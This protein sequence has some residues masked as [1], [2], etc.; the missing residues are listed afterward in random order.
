[1]NEEY[2]DIRNEIDRID[3]SIAD[4]LN[5]RFTLARRIIDDKISRKVQLN[6]KEREYDIINRAKISSGDPLFKDLIE[7]I[8]RN[9]FTYSKS[10]GINENQPGSLQ[11]VINTAPLLIAGPCAVEN[12]EQIFGLA[13]YLSAI[14]I[15][16]LRGSAFKP[17]TNPVS[18]Q[19][20]GA[21]GLDLIREAADKNNMFLINEVVDSEQLETYYDKIDIIQIGSR[22]MTSSGFLKQ[23][24]KMTAADKKPV[25]LKRGFASTI[26]E[27]LF[28]AQYIINEGN[29]NVMLCLRGIRT[30]E[31]IDSI[32]RYT[33][34]IASILELKL[35]S[36]LP[37]IFDP[38]H[39]SGD[40]GLVYIL[41]KMAL[42][43][44]VD[45]LMIETHFHPEE[46]L[47]DG[48]QS[49]HPEI[50]KDIIRVSKNPERL[51]S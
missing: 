23:V 37:V 5:Q 48:K 22:N 30:Y 10:P 8:Y 17:R 18:F 3:E 4:L 34:D 24:G 27:F 38:S 39:A 45:G 41:S 35:R 12:R 19:G 44:G 1:M 11:D 31:Q 51:L 50:V 49:V 43:A 15:K 40:A 47:S 6:D 26:S 28:A 7:K 46:A 42:L 14:G 2:K 32:F 16:V 33:P 21:P 13:E 29:P 25:M 36:H 9:I 20:L